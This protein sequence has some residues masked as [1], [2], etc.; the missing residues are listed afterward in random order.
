[1]PAMPVGAEELNLFDDPYHPHGGCLSIYESL[2]VHIVAAQVSAPGLLTGRNTKE[3]AAFAIEMAD[4]TVAQ[5]KQKNV[6][7]LADEGV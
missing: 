6:K 5:L 7:E 1:M 3:I 2:I 4:E